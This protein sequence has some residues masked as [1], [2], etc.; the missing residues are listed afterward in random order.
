MLVASCVEKKGEEMNGESNKVKEENV[1]KWRKHVYL[2]PIHIY[3]YHYYTVI[4]E[5]I[6]DSTT[7][8]SLMYKCQELYYNYIYRNFS[9]ALSRL[10][11]E[12]IFL[13]KFFCALLVASYA[14]KKG[15][16]MNEES[17][18]VMKWRR[19]VYLTSIHIFDYY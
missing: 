19:H 10:I 17:K 1:I 6:L 12:E 8:P 14:V 9:R 11:G 3:L 15:E 2:T 18:N 7:K 16:E 13:Q 4:Y 5:I